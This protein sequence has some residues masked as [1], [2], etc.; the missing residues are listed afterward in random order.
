MRTAEIRKIDPL[1]TLDLFSGV[2]AAE[3]DQVR[4]LC[5]KMEF[6]DGEIIVEENSNSTDMYVLTRGAAEVR[7]TDEHGH[8]RRLATLEPET[9][10]GEISMVLQQPR[11]ATVVAEG[12]TQVVRVDG[13]R[14]EEL[15]DADNIAVFKMAH[16]VLEMLAKRQSDMNQHLLDL[17]DR[18]EEEEH[19]I[20]DDVAS[21]RKRLVEEWSF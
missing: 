16:N 4:G 9:I 8:T 14:F 10:F 21:L 19:A 11:S 7:K 2:S 15:C 1:Q 13:D 6:D 20:H 3:F 18:L 5:F 17:A 12:E